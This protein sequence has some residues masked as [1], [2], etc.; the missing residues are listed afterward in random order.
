MSDL[1]KV[2]VVELFSVSA[3]HIVIL[4]CLHGFLHSRCQF[5]QTQREIDAEVG[6]RPVE[7]AVV[8]EVASVPCVL[9]SVLLL[10]E[11][12]GEQRYGESLLEHRFAQRQ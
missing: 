5:A 11:T 7:I 10:Q 8:C 6:C 12:V 3:F 4:Y 1:L 9:V 2:C